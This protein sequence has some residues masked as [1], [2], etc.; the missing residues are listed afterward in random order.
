MKRSKNIYRLP[1]GGKPDV[2]PAPFH[3][4]RSNNRFAVDFAL[5]VG[6]PIFAAHDGLVA[7]VQDGFLEGGLEPYYGDKANYVLIA[8][9][10]NEF[11]LYLHLKEGIAVKHFEEVE[12]GDLIGYCGLSGY[13]SYPHLHY[14]TAV[15]QKDELEPIATRFRIGEDIKVLISPQS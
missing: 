11:S 13:T 14:Q 5:K 8:H 1:F 4:H 15:K 12:E 6:A 10:D 9:P 2:R 3:Y 7:L